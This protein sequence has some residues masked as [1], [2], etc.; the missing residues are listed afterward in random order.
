M[1]QVRS[2]KKPNG[3]ISASVDASVSRLVFLPRFS[4][5]PFSARLRQKEKEWQREREKGGESA[6]CFAILW[7]TRFSPLPITCLRKYRLILRDSS[8]EFLYSNSLVWT[9]VEEF[10]LFFFLSSSFFFFFVEGF[11]GRIEVFFG[12]EENDRLIALVWG[13]FPICLKKFLSRV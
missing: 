2:E 1:R 12:S 3:S 11:R 8:S 7:E 13:I 5:P 10:S 9:L 6:T 4:F